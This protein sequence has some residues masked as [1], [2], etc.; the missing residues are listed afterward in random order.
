VY[1]RYLDLTIEFAAD[2]ESG[3]RSLASQKT[4]QIELIMATDDSLGGLSVQ[5][6][7]IGAGTV[8]DPREADPIAVESLNYRVWYR[9][10]AQDPQTPIV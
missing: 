7:L 9:T 5:V 4:L 6:V 1:D 10:S 8:H 3:F 2:G